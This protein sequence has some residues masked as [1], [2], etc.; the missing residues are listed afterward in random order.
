LTVLARRVK[1]NSGLG[2]V[3]LRRGI[4][5]FNTANKVDFRAFKKA[6]YAA[7]QATAADVVEATAAD[8]V[9][10]NFHQIDIRHVGRDLSVICNRSFPIVAFVKRPI[11]MS[12]VQF[13][14]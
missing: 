13:K 6:V 11:E 1:T 12:G 10:P 4:T 8:G 14:R 2:M 3:L 9:T 7:A 5:G